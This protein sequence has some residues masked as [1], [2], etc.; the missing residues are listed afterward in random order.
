MTQFVLEGKN[1]QKTYSD[2]RK[3][4]EVLSG[5]NIQ[6][7]KGETSRDCRRFRQR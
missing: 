3:E 2:G 6:I 1:L 5:L 7:K 4:V